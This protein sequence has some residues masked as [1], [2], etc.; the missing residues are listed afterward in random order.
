MRLIIL[1]LA[2]SVSYN[3]Y[4][5]TTIEYNGYAEYIH[6][7][8]K[9]MDTTE[10]TKYFMY[11]NKD[12]FFYKSKRQNTNNDSENAILSF[13]TKNSSNLDSFELAKIKLKVKKD[14]EDSEPKNL[15]FYDK[16]KEGYTSKSGDT[17]ILVLDTLVKGTFQLT[18]DTCTINKLFC[19]KA[20]YTSPKGNI[21]YIWFA[22]KVPISINP[23]GIY[24]L[25]GI[26][27]LLESGDKNW[28]ILLKKLEYPLKKKV[29]EIVDFTKAIT[30]SENAK[31]QKELRERAGKP[32][33]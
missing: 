19:Q 6:Y 5:Q 2:I 10:D 33:N 1:V 27:V 23:N 21:L 7:T 4:T 17:K 12:G 24:G 3:C 30:K 18:N 22:E 9:N 26:A 11:F 16:R 25:P 29:I 32:L 28:S 8:F 14:I 15:C 31:K 13:I 20:I